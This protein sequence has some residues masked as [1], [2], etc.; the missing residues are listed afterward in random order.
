MF[1][2]VQNLWSSHRQ[3]CSIKN[4]EI[5]RLGLVFAE[6]DLFHNA[7]WPQFSLVEHFYTGS[8]WQFQP[9][10]SIHIL[11]L[12]V[13]GN[14]LSQFQLLFYCQTLRKYLI[15]W[16]V[17][18]SILGV[19]SIWMMSVSLCGPKCPEFSTTLRTEHQAH[20]RTPRKF[21]VSSAKSRNLDNP[22]RTS[23]FPVH[24]L[25]QKHNFVTNNRSFFVDGD[26]AGRSQHGRVYKSHLQIIHDQLVPSQQ[27]S[28]GYFF[29]GQSACQES[30]PHRIMFSAKLR[31]RTIQILRFIADP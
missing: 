3:R 26:S 11:P 22:D 27:D 2:R 16:L 14:W 15:N 5:C 29:C 9:F 17:Q 30:N 10:P 21:S 28:W 18:D 19:A 4:T 7:T 20:A 1:A 12:P 6:L 23:S 31:L 8:R 13:S 24:R 25:T